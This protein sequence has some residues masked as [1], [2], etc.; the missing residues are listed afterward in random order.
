[1]FVKPTRIEN[2]INE[3]CFGFSLVLFLYAL[4]FHQKPA[5]FAEKP[6]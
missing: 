4:S 6:T 2:E 3:D 5:Y 1:V